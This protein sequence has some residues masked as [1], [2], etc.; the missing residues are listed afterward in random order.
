M[1]CL[2]PFVC[3]D[4]VQRPGR[5]PRPGSVAVCAHCAT[6][7]LFTADGGGGLTV[8]WPTAEEHAELAA[9]PT[10]ATL[11][12]QAQGH[13]R[14]SEIVQAGRRVHRRGQQDRVAGEPVVAAGRRRGWVT[15]RGGH[16]PE[17]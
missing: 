1:S 16:A 7:Q 13:R 9:D 3:N 5:R 10:V 11:V 14:P 6:V 17:G 12:A 8:R 2:A 15:R 4:S